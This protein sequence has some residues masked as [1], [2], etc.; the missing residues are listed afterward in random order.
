LEDYN[1]A[2]PYLLRGESPPAETN[3]FTI[4]KL[5][6]EFMLAKERK[7]KAGELGAEMFADYLKIQN[8]LT[9]VFGISRQ[10]ES[11]GAPDFAK[12]RATMSD[13]WGPVRVKNCITRVKSFFKFALESDL[14]SKLPQYGPEF[15]K[16]DKSV[17]RR[18][19]AESGKKILEPA[20]VRLL[21]ADA[22]PQLKAMILLGVNCGFGNTDCATLPLSSIDLKTGW[23]DYARPKTG[24]HRRCPLWPETI[25]ALESAIVR[26]ESTAGKNSKL[27]F[28][29]EVG[30][31]MIRM[32]DESR[33]DLIAVQFGRLLKRVGLHRE[34]IGFY[35]L[36]HVFRTIADSARDPVAIDLIMGHSDPSMGAHYREK[37]DDSRLVAVSNHV[38][39]WLFGAEKSK[40]HRRKQVADS[41]LPGSQKP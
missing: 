4:A 13:R 41:S 9:N 30:T 31:V 11:L 15:K 34:G 38:R 35:T 6:N 2:A 10:V 26:T 19:R 22:N 3:G 8:L 1:K 21:L 37:I 24:I 18:H 36:R 5:C 7:M 20:D 16:P 32:E 23:I 17:L 27:A 39:Q 14:I 29:S 28:V 40:P 12:L 33:L 25:T